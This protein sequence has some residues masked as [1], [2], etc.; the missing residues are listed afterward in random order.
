MK[1]RGSGKDQGESVRQQAHH[2]KTIK[3][4]LLRNS[5]TDMQ[6]RSKQAL[7][8]SLGGCRGCL[9][10][11]P[12]GSQRM[13]CGWQASVDCSVATSTSCLAPQILTYRS[14]EALVSWEMSSALCLPQGTRAHEMRLI[15]LSQGWCWGSVG[16][17]VLVPFGSLH[18][19]NDSSAAK[20]RTWLL[21]HL[22]QQRLGV[23]AVCISKGTGKKGK[24]NPVPQG[25]HF[26]KGYLLSTCLHE[27]AKVLSC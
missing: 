18:L 12:W 2:R 22:P 14:L 3:I 19:S 21:F 20:K 10:W 16:K 13:G 24:E 26:W 27:S 1:A 11:T 8:I 9:W 7:K 5:I 4:K 25:L 17:Q 15:S 6:R 23:H